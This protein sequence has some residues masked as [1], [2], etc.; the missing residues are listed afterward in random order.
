MSATTGYYWLVQFCADLA[1]LEAVNVG[2]VSLSSEAG[3]LSIWTSGVV[4]SIVIV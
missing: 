1:R 2:V 3:L 4:R